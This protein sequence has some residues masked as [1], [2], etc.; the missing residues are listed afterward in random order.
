M[1]LSQRLLTL[2]HS[3]ILLQLPPYLSAL[4]ILVGLAWVLILPLNEYSRNTYVSEN[5]ILPGQ[6]HTYFGG[7]EHDV[8]RAYRQEVWQ[9]SQ[10]QESERIAGLR[11]ILRSMGLKDAEQSYEY[12]I[13]GESVAGVNAYGVLQGPRADATE[14]MVLVAAWI[15]FNGDINYSGVALTL[16]LARYFSRWSVWSKDIIILI[17]A[18]STYGPIAW[19]DAYHAASITPTSARNISSLPI[20]AGALQAAVAL[21]YPAGPWGQRFDKLNLVYDGINGALPNLD[22]LNTVVEI[23]DHQMGVKCYLHDVS[24]HSD[25]YVDRLKTIAAGIVTQGV[26]HA[27]GPHSAF[28]PYHIDAITLKTEGD[29]W[30]DEMT[31]GRVTESV[32]RSI[33]NLLEHLHQSFFFYILLSPNRFVSIGNYLPAAMLI[34][35]NFTV[36]ALAL[37]VLS[38]R[39]TVPRVTSETPAKD[40]K[41]IKMGQVKALVPKAALETA[42]R[43]VF[44]PAVVV[45]AVHASSAVP[46]YLMNNTSAKWAI[47]SLAAIGVSQSLTAVLPGALRGTLQQYQIIQ[48]ISLLL[49][50][51]TLSMM[52]TLNFSL[53]LVIG[54]LASPLSFVRPLPRMW[55]GGHPSIKWAIV[56]LAALAMLAI[57]PPVVLAVAS[58]VAE[59]DVAW[60]TTELA[61]GWSG[62]GAITNL[63][64]WC[65]WWPAWML[66]SVVLYSGF[67]TVQ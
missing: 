50:G 33:N 22:L 8:F 58:K 49:L 29:G 60:F 24:Q 59:R 52:A 35:G 15:N 7:S 41:T 14:A 57:S 44:L 38:G 40:M 13:A 34:A 9:L 18:D 30:H 46:L 51:A 19:V 6:V 11:D 4:C 62:Q 1:A 56:P 12:N 3:P 55:L 47:A 42:E 10:K 32:F 16:A 20:K 39:K 25:S 66:G 5:A 26:G 17:P 37:W 2:R 54:V 28:M 65:V 31:L 67:Y 64:I 45:L 53:A 63:V 48:A 61:K 21:D 23:A 27:T 36:T 43:S